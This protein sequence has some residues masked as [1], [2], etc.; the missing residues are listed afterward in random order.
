MSSTTGTP[1]RIHLLGDGRLEEAIAA[2]AITPGH[3]IKLDS[4]AKVLVHATAGGYAEKAF[5]L[6]DA[7]QGYTI[8]TAYALNDRV[9]YILAKAGDVVYA[10]LAG[11]ETA[12]IGS[13]L[14]SN[15][16]GTLKVAGG[17]DVVIAVA[18]EAVDAT[19]SNDVDE[20]ITV[21]VL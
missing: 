10:W 20:R 7:L 21:R 13:L 12:V 11:N 8:A 19:D 5:A 14:T 4:A 15:A 17:T 6:E 1:T 3:L 9:T 16:D 2:A 18:L